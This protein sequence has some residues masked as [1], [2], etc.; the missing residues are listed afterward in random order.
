VKAGHRVSRYCISLVLVLLAVTLLFP[1]PSEARRRPLTMA[2]DVKG[3]T[4][5]EFW[6]KVQEEGTKWAGNRLRIRKMASVPVQGFD[7]RGGLSPVWEAQLVRCDSVRGQDAAEEGSAGGNTCKGRSVNIRVVE[8][9]VIGDDAGMRISKEV[10]FRGSAMRMDR[11]TVSAQR[12]EEAANIHRQYRPTDTDNYTYELR[13]DQRGDRPVWVI[14]R[15]CGYKG[16][17]EGRCMPG[18]HW[19]VKVDAES[20]EIVK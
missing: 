13:F 19:I 8:S 16:T 12:A 14:K 3:I 6:S 4:F 2:K 18:D 11:I 15:T 20:G 10:H 1:A 9:G 5:D 7:G 17:S